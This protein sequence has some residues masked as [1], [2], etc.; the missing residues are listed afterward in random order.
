MPDIISDISGSDSNS[1]CSY[2]YAKEYMNARLHTEPWDAADAKTRK[3]AMVMAT[4][5]IESEFQGRWYGT[6]TYDS[7]ALAHPRT[8][9][10]DP[11]GRDV[12]E[13][14]IAK[15]LVV[16]ELE[17]TLIFLEEDKFA[18]LDTLG[19]SKFKVSTISVEFDKRDRGERFP[20]FVYNLLSAYL[21]ESSHSAS[22]KLVRC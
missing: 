16:A 22:V 6:L 2:E 12:P 17:M 14:E 9:L 8:N 18:D 21:R 10:V 5:A 19:I 3:S 15:N 20:A 1:Y 7:Q 13:N 11:E 4:L